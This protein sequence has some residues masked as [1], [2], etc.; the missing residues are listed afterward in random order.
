MAEGPTGARKLG[1]VGRTR[2]R[3]RTRAKT[4]ET[5]EDP[6]EAVADSH[7]AESREILTILRIKR[8]TKSTSMSRMK[9]TGLKTTIKARLA[10]EEQEE[11][12]KEL[13]TG[14]TIPIREAEEARSE[15]E[16]EMLTDKAKT[17]IEMPMI[18]LKNTKARFLGLSRQG[19]EEVRPSTH[20][21][22]KTRSP[23]SREEEGL[24]GELEANLTARIMQI[25][26]QTHKDL[27]TREATIE[28]ATIKIVSIRNPSK[29]KRIFG[30]I[31]IF[32]THREA[33]TQIL[34][35]RIIIQEAEGKTRIEEGEHLQ[36]EETSETEIISIPSRLEGDSMVFATHKSTNPS[37]APSH[38]KTKIIRDQAAQGLSTKKSQT[39]QAKNSLTMAKTRFKMKE[40][41]QGP[42]SSTQMASLKI[43][44]DMFIRTKWETWSRMWG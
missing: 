1:V 10:S 6:T 35:T 24:L 13:V 26:T 8:T 3:T 4:S 23:S 39:E 21:D 22:L 38:Q 43:S 31:F 42:R 29:K 11:L 16:E 20:R 2:T 33:K 12:I 32:S 14:I 40:L 28:E 17:S 5:R 9:K 36:F 27:R 37:L 30:K 25:C 15:E 44:K 18:T 34:S 7:R 19:Q 41:I